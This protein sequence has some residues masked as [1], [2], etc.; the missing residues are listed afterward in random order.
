MSKKKKLKLTQIEQERVEGVLAKLQLA[1]AQYRQ[2]E[3]LKNAIISEVAGEG[4]VIEQQEDGL[5]R[6]KPDKE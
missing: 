2:V 4:Y 6:K 3:A 1:A 5:Y